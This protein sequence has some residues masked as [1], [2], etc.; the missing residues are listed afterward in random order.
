MLHHAHGFAVLNKVAFGVLKYRSGKHANAHTQAS[1]NTQAPPAAH[2]SAASTAA[3][4]SRLAASLP[5]RVP[6]DLL[7][8]RLDNLA[9]RQKKRKR[10]RSLP[11]AFSDTRH[12]IMAKSKAFVN[13]E[14]RILDHY[15]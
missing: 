1:T 11:S 14:A 7:L 5:L 4:L 9:L 12:N 2:L 10:I 3:C 8:V 13:C 15:L 6:A